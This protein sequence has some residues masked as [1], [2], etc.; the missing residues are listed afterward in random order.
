M[1]KYNYIFQKSLFYGCLLFVLFILACGKDDSSDSQ[2]ATEG[3][4]PVP[5]NIQYLDIADAKVK[6]DVDNIFH[7]NA[8]KMLLKDNFSQYYYYRNVI[9]VD[10]H[11]YLN[12]GFKY[13]IPIW[14]DSSVERLKIKINDEPDNIAKVLS[15]KEDK[16]F[17]VELNKNLFGKSGI[18]LARKPIKITLTMVALNGNS[19]LGQL[20]CVIDFS[21]VYSGDITLIISGDLCEPAYCAFGFCSPESHK[22][23]S[24]LTHTIRLEKSNYVN[25]KSYDFSRIETL[26]QHMAPYIS[27]RYDLFSIQSVSVNGNE[28]SG[29]LNFSINNSAKTVTVRA[30][31]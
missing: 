19:K 17:L 27:G 21:P 4:T 23:L 26:S 30:K 8:E 1:R 15:K 25:P 29:Y 13:Y 22:Q 10:L 2:A 24:N 16:Y 9:E 11:Q 7:I 20:S 14:V 5:A 28:L 12:D 6:S 3:S 31:N 18:D